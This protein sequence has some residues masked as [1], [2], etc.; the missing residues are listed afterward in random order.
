[1]AKKIYT[2]P[3]GETWT[4]NTLIQME[5]GVEVIQFKDVE[6]VDEWAY[7]PKKNAHQKKVVIKEKPKPFT[8]VREKLYNPNGKGTAA[9]KI[10]IKELKHEK[11]VAKNRK[12]KI[13]AQDKKR[14]K[15]SVKKATI[16]EVTKDITEEQKAKA[17]AH[18]QEIIRRRFERYT[19]RAVIDMNAVVAYPL[20]NKYATDNNMKRSDLCVIIILSSMGQLKAN[21]FTKYGFSPYMINKD[22]MP[23]LMDNDLVACFGEGR[24]KLYV[25]TLIGKKLIINFRSYY[26][27]NMDVILQSNEYKR[28]YQKWQDA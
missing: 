23:F 25:S 13:P 26:K 27:K 3:E 2:K 21:D 11:K 12:W 7:V 18:A 17:K 4:G 24:N 10:K 5:D 14:I 22:T 16:K 6:L 15:I 28:E 19:Q 1:M 20:I 8:R 9:L